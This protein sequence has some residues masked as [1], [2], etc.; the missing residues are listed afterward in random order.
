MS[1]AAQLALLASGREERV[2]GRVSLLYE[3]QQ[4]ADIDLQTL[5]AAALTGE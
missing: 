5:H 3:P 2:R 1:L 4:A